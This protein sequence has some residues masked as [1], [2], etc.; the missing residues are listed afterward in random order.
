MNPHNFPN[1]HSIL[2][3]EHWGWEQSFWRTQLALKASENVLPIETKT[4]FFQI[5]D[6]T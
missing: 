4:L 6:I 3:R 2:E 5:Y 1:L